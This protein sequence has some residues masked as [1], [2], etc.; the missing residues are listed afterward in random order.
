MCLL[1]EDC[2]AY[3]MFDRKT[4]DKKSVFGYLNMKNK[5]HMM[6]LCE[7]YGFSGKQAKNQEK[8]MSRE[9]IMIH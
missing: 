6:L 9:L 8:I 3:L 4:R 2:L 7:Q 5:E 1:A